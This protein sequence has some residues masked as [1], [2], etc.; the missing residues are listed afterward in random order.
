MNVQEMKV[1]GT[2]DLP[3]EISSNELGWSLEMVIR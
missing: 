3:G 2:F 1:T